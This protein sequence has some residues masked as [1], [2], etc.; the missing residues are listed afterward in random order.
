MVYGENSRRRTDTT[1]V[2]E[3]MGKALAISAVARAISRRQEREQCSAAAWSRAAALGVT[4]W[5]ASY[6]VRQ[7]GVATNT[8]TQSFSPVGDFALEGMLLALFWLGL[9]VAVSL[10]SLTGTLRVEESYGIA[11]RWRTG[12]RKRTPYGNATSATSAPISERSRYG[13]GLSATTS[14]T[15]PLAR[16]AMT[17][18][19]DPGA[20][21]TRASPDWGSA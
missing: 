3:T 11:W 18:T 19:R 20:R 13:P 1:G 14:P 12:T 8:R 6:L 4:V 7:P 9:I 2:T 5:S 17:R 21:L 16:P 10:A 15:R